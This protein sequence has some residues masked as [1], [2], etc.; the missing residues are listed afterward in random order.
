MDEMAAE[1]RAWI[2]DNSKAVE[3]RSSGTSS[4]NGN[5]NRE[6]DKE[7]GLRESK[8]NVGAAAVAA[9]DLYDF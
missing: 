4:T 7:G 2:L 1:I 3:S 6:R 5:G 9:D 8:A